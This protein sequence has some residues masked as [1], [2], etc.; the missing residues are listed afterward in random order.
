M[1][2][3]RFIA[4]FQQ[5]IIAVGAESKSP[6]LECIDGDHRLPK[7]KEQEAV[8]GS[9][10]WGKGKTTGPGLRSSCSEAPSTHTGEIGPLAS[11]FFPVFEEKH[12][13]NSNPKLLKFYR[14]V[15]GQAKPCLTAKVS[16]LAFTE[17]ETGSRGPL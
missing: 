2:N 16:N 5:R 4:L 1:G 11:G 13:L 3:P 7:G 6:Q 14:T 10:D 12:K 8:G 15:S 9:K 17:V